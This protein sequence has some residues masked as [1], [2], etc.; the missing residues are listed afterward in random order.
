MAK[1]LDHSRVL[2]TPTL[3]QVEYTLSALLSEQ[4]PV[5]Y[6]VFQNVGKDGQ[7]HLC[8]VRLLFGTFFIPFNQPPVERA[9]GPKAPALV[10][11]SV[12]VRTQYLPGRSLA[13]VILSPEAYS[14]ANPAS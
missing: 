1:P 12:T 8:P 3:T 4:T 10:L 14:V 2:I 6:S 11:L 13:L 5:L 9:K 7:S